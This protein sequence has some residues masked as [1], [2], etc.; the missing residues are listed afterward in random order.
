[1]TLQEQ[2]AVAFKELVGRSPTI[3]I[4]APGRINLLGAHIDYCAGWVLPGAIEQ[5]IWL[6]AAPSANNLV[7]ITALNLQESGR[8]QLPYL[9]VQASSVTGHWINYPVGVAW[10]LQ[11]AGHTPV[12]MDVVVAGDLP[13][14]AGLSSS[15]ALEMAF[16]QAWEV[17]SGFALDGLARAQIGHKTEND[18]LGLQSGIM[19]QFAAVHGKADHLILLDCR[20]MAH[21]WVPLPPGLVVLIAES[22]VRRKLTNSAYNSRQEECAR[23]TAVLQ[24]HLPHIKTLRDVS[25]DELELY[26]HHLPE[27]LRRRAL[28]VVGECE[29]VPAGAA[30]LKRGDLTQFARLVRQSH[31][32]SRDN[33]ET[34]TPELD[35]LAAAAWPV[36]GCYGARF[37]GGG[38]GGVMQVLAE[39]TAVPAIRQAM[40]DAFAG[41]YD[42]IPP[43]FVT[44]IGDGVA[45]V[46]G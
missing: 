41:E 3:I 14:E 38:G 46:Q 17:L 19:D 8:F 13:M 24:T 4:R 28:H 32:S 12:G 36:P 20:S 5:A 26:S 9:N 43:M 31:I 45:V 11:E 2:I 18:Y 39:E 1:M 40:S 30:A 7:S 42:R 10:A 22:G 15:A 21:E 23:A 34:S 25:M 44:G 35:T 37:A 6:A 29:R 16:V 33:F 27:P